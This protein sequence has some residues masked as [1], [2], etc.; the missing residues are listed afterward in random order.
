MTKLPVQP[1]DSADDA[2]IIQIREPQLGTLGN[3]NWRQN[4]GS[5]RGYHELRTPL[6]A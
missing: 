6:A 2:H 4:G 5:A 3:M 1:A